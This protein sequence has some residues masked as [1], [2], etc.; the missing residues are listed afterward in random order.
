MS[1][2]V[3]YVCNVGYVVPRSNLMQLS[4][5]DEISSPNC[6]LQRGC[7][8][9]SSR[10]SNSYLAGWNLVSMESRNA[11]HSFHGKVQLFYGSII[12]P[13]YSLVEA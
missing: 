9:V 6:L 12:M 2:D 8:S 10:S 4:T 1:R 11:P 5:Q 13:L 7:V 3:V